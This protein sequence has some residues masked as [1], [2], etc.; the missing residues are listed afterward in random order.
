MLNLMEE[1]TYNLYHV[2]QHGRSNLKDPWSIRQTAVYQKFSFNDER[3]TWT[4]VQLAKPIR[5]IIEKVIAGAKPRSSTTRGHWLLPILVHTMILT[6]SQRKWKT[7]IHY[8]AE[9]LASLVSQRSPYPRAIP[10]H[11]CH[12]NYLLTSKSS[13]KSHASQKSIT[14][15]LRTTPSTS[16]IAKPWSS[17]KEKSDAVSH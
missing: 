9:R 6:M 5:N 8:L 7:Y 11:T 2:E 15:Q 16:P 3:S 10:A 14:D 17:S 4:M 12:F 13:M 1:I